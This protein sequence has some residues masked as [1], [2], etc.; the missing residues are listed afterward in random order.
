MSQISS[1]TIGC[2]QHATSVLGSK[3]TGQIIRELA[4]GP[5]RF[6]ELERALP[7]LNPRTLSKRLDE[8]S[9]QQIITAR[10]QARGYSLTQ[11]GS[12]LLPVLHEM[13]VWGTK[14]PESSTRL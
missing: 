9:H 10:G 2:V 6:C 13:V 4:S 1:S 3:W 11:K 7:A 8:L 12:D 5:K 14:Y